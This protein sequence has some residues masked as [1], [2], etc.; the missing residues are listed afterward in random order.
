MSC[1]PNPLERDIEKAVCA[2][3]KTKGCYVRKFTSPSHR[4]VPDRL[5]ITPAG[6]VFFMELK[7]RGEKPTPGQT[8]EIDKIRKMNVKVFVCDN[9]EDGKNVVESMCDVLGGY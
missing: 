2:F 1:N 8:I 4:S 5:F 3:A 7:R 9:V 6:T